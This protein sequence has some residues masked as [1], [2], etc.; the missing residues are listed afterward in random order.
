MIRHL[1]IMI[2]NQRK[3][4][5]W[6]FLELALVVCLLWGLLDSF[7]VDEYTYHRP[8]G[9]DIE[10]VYRINLGRIAESSPAF[11]PDSL[12]DRTEGE[13]L[14]RLLELL[15]R[16]P[17]VEATCVAVCGCPY[18]S[19]N[20]WSALVH[21]EADST[22][23]GSGVIRMREVSSA[24]FDVFRMTDKQGRPLREAMEENA[25]P[26]VI[27]EELEAILFGEESA[28]GWSLKWSMDDPRI[29]PVAAVSA[30]IRDN[31]YKA[32]EPCAFIVRRTG[33]EVVKSANDHQVLQMECL[34]RLR[35]EMEGDRLDRLFGQ[36]QEQAT[37][38]NLYIS[39]LTP[40]TEMR[41]EALKSRVDN[42]KKKLALISFMML[43]I[44][45]GIVG[46]FWL[47]TQL[48]RGEIG[49]RMALGA[50]RRTLKSFLFTEGLL[51]LALTLPIALAFLVNALALDWPDTA[52][53]PYTGWRFLLTFGGAYFL[54]GAMI[55]LG[56]W[57][58]A[59][60]VERMDPAEALRYE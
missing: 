32:S 17:E 53:L 21:A 48:R 13:D 43:N 44:F 16:I 47:R 54:M 4:N 6:L 27:S 39:S 55:C 18:L 20:W 36:M 37:A 40:L 34:V 5:V 29:M 14:L 12:R 3:S 45:F 15:E 7:L 2:W 25:G 31:P 23:A 49:L 38:G 51:V 26:L 11:Q 10:R 9:M 1:M 60:K 41:T 33:Q 57:F 46:T 56:I 58:P 22:D 35:E 42:H 30:P 19:R 50:S 52:R 28:V 8:L 59:R 24:Y